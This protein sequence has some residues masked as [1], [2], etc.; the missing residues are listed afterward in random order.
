MT[1]AWFDLAAAGTVHPPAGSAPVGEPAPVD[2]VAVRTVVH[3]ARE[4]EHPAGEQ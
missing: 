2:M 4:A 1:N 3:A